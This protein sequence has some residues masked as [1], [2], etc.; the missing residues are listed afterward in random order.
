MVARFWQEPEVRV[1]QAA[2]AEPVG[3]EAKV[4]PVD[5][6]QACSHSLPM[7]PVEPPVQASGP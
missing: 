6:C 3:L 2:L 1:E 5:S 7:H 4:V